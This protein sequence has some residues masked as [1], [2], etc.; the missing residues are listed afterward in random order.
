MGTGLYFI[1]L[2]VAAAVG[3][4]W[5]KIRRQRKAASGSTTR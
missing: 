2:I 1:T 4:G 5:V 3:I